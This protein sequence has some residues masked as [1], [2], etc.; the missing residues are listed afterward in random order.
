MGMYVR[1]KKMHE[2]NW[3]DF[4]NQKRT[5]DRKDS[6]S[7]ATDIGSNTELSLEEMKVDGHDGQFLTGSP[8]FI[9]DGNA[10]TALDQL[11]KEDLSSSENDGFLPD[12]PQSIQR[13][14]PVTTSEP[15]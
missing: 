6:T 12:E 3:L 14:A 1:L 5:P 11:D 4:E 2:K 15:I 10:D 8:R 7:E 9:R 13:G